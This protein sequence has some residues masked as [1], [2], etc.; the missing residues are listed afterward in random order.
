MAHFSTCPRA[1]PDVL[2]NP[3]P[4]PDGDARL[5]LLSRLESMLNFKRHI[6]LLVEGIADKR[7]LVDEEPEISR[8]PSWDDGALD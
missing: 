3:A 8:V 1:V 6:R 5:E 2:W 4:G 7:E